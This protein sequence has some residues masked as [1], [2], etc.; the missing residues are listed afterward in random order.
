M[1]KKISVSYACVYVYVENG[2]ERENGNMATVNL[3]EKGTSRIVTILF[4]L[5]FPL[6]YKL[7]KIKVLAYLK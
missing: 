2:I 5:S 7:F 3:E 1:I 6:F 4:F